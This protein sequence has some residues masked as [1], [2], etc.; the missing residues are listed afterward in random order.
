MLAAYQNQ[1]TSLEA[2][3]EQL[4]DDLQRQG[5]EYQLLLDIKSRLQLEIEEYRRLLDGEFSGYV[6]KLMMHILD[7]LNI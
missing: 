7:F 4:K 1:V 5:H 6:I 3:L 2:Q